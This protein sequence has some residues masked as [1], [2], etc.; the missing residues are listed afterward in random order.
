M[1]QWMYYFSLSLRKPYKLTIYL[2]IFSQCLR[3]F[4]IYFYSYVIYLMSYIRL[5]SNPLKFRD[6]EWLGRNPRL[7]FIGAT[8]PLTR[9]QLRMILISVYL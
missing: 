5:D 7:C 3:V 9:T 6:I 1:L 8:S 2:E 4:L